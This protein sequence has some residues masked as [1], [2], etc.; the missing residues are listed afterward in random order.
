M[1]CYQ[2]PHPSNIFYQLAAEGP[3]S[4][5]EAVYTSELS[6]DWCVLQVMNS[7]VFCFYCAV[8]CCSDLDE[9]STEPWLPEIRR[10]ETMLSCSS[11]D[12]F[13]L[14]YNL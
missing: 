12:H 2:S 10:G 13:V 9:K 14:F 3:I 1:L 11:E 4:H 8:A 7:T 5:R 6:G